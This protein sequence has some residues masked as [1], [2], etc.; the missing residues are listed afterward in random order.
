MNGL[1]IVECVRRIRQLTP[2]NGDCRFRLRNEEV[3]VAKFVHL[4]PESQVARI[5]RH[6]IRARAAKDAFPGGVFAV[7][8]TRN[9]YASHQW[10]RELTAAMCIPRPVCGM[11]RPLPCSRGIR[12]HHRSTS[13]AR[14]VTDRTVHGPST[15][16][17]R[18]VR[19]TA[20]IGRITLNVAHESPA[21]PS[22]R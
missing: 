16:S 3:H 12:L 10:L 13:A 4:A 20:G 7:A 22:A 8:V 18:A 9:F 21:R 15:K 19:C 2:R 17:F 6:G 14:A 11:L 5:R 1:T